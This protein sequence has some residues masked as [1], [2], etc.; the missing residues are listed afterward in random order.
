MGMD[1]RVDYT[2]MTVNALGERGFTKEDVASAASEASVAHEK[3]QANRGKGM[4][5]WM[6]LMYEQDD[7]VEDIIAT[8]KKVREKFRVFVVLGIGGSALGPIAVAQ[9]LRHLYYNELSDE[10]RGG[11]RF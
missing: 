7:I 5:G 3:V 11:P 8:A 10:K 2:N 1:I 6:Q 4:Q 9:A